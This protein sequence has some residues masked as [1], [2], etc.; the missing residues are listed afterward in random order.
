MTGRIMGW[1]SISRFSICGRQREDIKAG[2]FDFSFTPYRWHRPVLE[3]NWVLINW[4]RHPIPLL[5]LLLCLS[6]EKTTGG[7]F[8]S[9]T[10]PH[11]HYQLSPHFR[12][13]EKDERSEIV[14]G[15]N[16]HGSFE[17]QRPYLPAWLW[18]FFHEEFFK[19]SHDRDVHSTVRWWLVD[20]YRN[21]WLSRSYLQ[22]SKKELGDSLQISKKKSC[23]DKNWTR[24][25]N[26]NRAKN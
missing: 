17:S 25:E 1:T 22:H 5:A 15:K 20:A 14:E 3:E 21:T 16:F 23:L 26:N 24:V 12:C 10:W 11:P 2:A 19:R 13:T 8:Q 7:P 4:R 18:W 6:F 9:M